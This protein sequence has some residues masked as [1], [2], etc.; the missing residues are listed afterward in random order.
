MGLTGFVLKDISAFIGPVGYTLKGLH[1]EVLKSQQPTAFIR[2]ARIMQGRRDMTLLSENVK[3]KQRVEQEVSHGWAVILEVWGIME[4]KKTEG[5]MGR[6][7]V[8]RQRRQWRA[9]GAFEN[10]VMAEMAV[11]ATRRGEGLEETFAEQRKELEK[12][13]RPRK[14]V[15]GELQNRKKK[16]MEE[17]GAKKSAKKGAEKG[18]K[19]EGEQSDGVA[20]GQ[21]KESRSSA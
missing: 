13:D 18:A 15:V 3:D 6:M 1:K 14:N 11:E 20:S 10:V 2:K 21:V 8:L 19:K 9:N 17:K 7:R 5:L 4:E 16:R 12:V